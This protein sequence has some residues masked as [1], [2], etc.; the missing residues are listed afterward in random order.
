MQQETWVMSTLVGSRQCTSWQSTWA[1]YDLIRREGRGRKGRGVKGGREGG[2][3]KEK[4]EG[5]GEER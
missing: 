1:N 2:K 5:N 4:G 3:G